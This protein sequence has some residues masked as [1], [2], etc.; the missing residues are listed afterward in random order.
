[1]A[2]EKYEKQ[3]LFYS[4][5]KTQQ[6]RPNFDSQQIQRCQIYGTAKQLVCE[7]LIQLTDLVEVDWLCTLPYMHG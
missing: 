7:E 4:C 1:M 3:C 5:G 2:L 6:W